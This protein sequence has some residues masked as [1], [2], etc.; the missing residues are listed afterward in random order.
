[1]AG[2]GYKLFNTGDVLLAS[3]VNT[4]LMQ[5]T[6]MV[7]ADSAARTT[8]L[9]GVLAEG[10]I[11][12]LADTNATE[13]YNGSAWVS[14]SGTGDITAVTTGANSGLAGGAT[15]GAADIKIN[16]A[17]KGQLAVGTGS[18]TTDFL[19]V[20]TNGHTLV[21]DSATATGL[22]WAAASSTPTFVGCSLNKTADQTGITNNVWTV[23]SWNQEDFDTDGFHDN[24]TNN[25]RITI[26]AGKNGKY[27]FVAIVGWSGTSNDIGLRLYKNGSGGVIVYNSFSGDQGMTLTAIVDA[28]VSDYFEIYG[29]QASGS[30]K[31]IYGGVY[32][33]FYAQYLGA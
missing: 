7:F 22:K 14:V 12:Y 21:A 27:L 24:S 26:P 10:M 23:I 6:V 9:S 30:D 15:S 20:G 3:E 2:A 19:T 5:Q 8:A 31:S 18:G 25:S 17:S 4:Y 11:S 32:S 28:S 1:M 16:F 13:V 33:R 29:K